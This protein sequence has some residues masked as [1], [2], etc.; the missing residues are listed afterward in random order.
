MRRMAQRFLVGL[1]AL[2]LA[3]AGPASAQSKKRSGRQTQSQAA[4]RS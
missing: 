4:R 2:S 3:L 1:T